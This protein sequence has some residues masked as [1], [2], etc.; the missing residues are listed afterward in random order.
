MPEPRPRRR[1]EYELAARNDGMD[2]ARMALKHLVVR[3][4]AIERERART[5]GG[6]LDGRVAIDRVERLGPR[7]ERPRVSVVLTLY[8]FAD[9]VGDALR[10]VALSDMR[11][12]RA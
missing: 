8:N 9:Y 7:V 3:Q 5:C 1:P 6:R 12:A 11:D 10:S 2:G 4:R